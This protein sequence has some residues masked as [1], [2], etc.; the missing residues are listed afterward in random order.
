MQRTR[1]AF[2]LIEILIVVIILGIMAAMVVPQFVNATYEAST[3]AAV[4]EVQK[5]RRAIEVYQ[6]RNEN[7]L[8]DVTPGAGTWGGL[9]RDAGEYL[10]SAPLNPYVGAVNDNVIVYGVGPDPAYQTTHAWIYNPATGEVWAGGFDAEDN[11][12]PKP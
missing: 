5:L 6:V 10:K 1:R 3:K 4:H 2:T 8:P 11:P 7:L 9:T 12:L